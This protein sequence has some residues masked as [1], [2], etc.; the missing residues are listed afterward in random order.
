[1]N[2]NNYKIPETE[3]IIKV[4]T[5]QVRCDLDHPVV[6]Y[7]IGDKG[8]VVCDYCNVKYVYEE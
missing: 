1:M 3:Q 7:V 6:Y 5:H 2:K 4:N 8:F